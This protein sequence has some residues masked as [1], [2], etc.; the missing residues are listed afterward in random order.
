MKKIELIKA[1]QVDHISNEY[2]ILK[3]IT[4]PFVVLL[5]LFRSIFREWT[6]IVNTYTFSWSILLVANFLLI[7]VKKVCLNLIKLRN[8]LS[9]CRFYAAQLV[10]IF[11]Y[12]HSKNVIY[13]DLKP[14]NVLLAPDGYIKLTDFGFAKV[15]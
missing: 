13:R 2:Q 9:Y 5:F 6:K 8:L 11:E 3:S 15:I 7:F 4:H 14:E 12:L 1:Q 10:L